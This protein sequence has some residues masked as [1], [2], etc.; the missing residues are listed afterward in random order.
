MQLISMIAHT[1]VR[2]FP[3][4]GICV[5]INENGIPICSL[6]KKGTRSRYQIVYSPSGY[7]G[8]KC[9][10]FTETQID[11]INQ[12]KECHHGFIFSIDMAAIKSKKK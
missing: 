11:A 1:N 9:T 7:K 8:M 5:I 4:S 2:L 12:R 10:K 6:R 3:K